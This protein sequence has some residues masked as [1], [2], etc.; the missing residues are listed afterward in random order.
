MHQFQ[1]VFFFEFFSV[2]K[3][4]FPS[5]KHMSKTVRM[6]YQNVSYDAYNAMVKLSTIVGMCL[7][8]GKLGSK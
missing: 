3:P 5:L 7:K 2:S 1:T 4:I 8:L 6:G